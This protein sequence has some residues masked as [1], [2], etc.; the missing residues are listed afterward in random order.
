MPMTGNGKVQVHCVPGRTRICVAS[1]N[2]KCSV[3]DHRVILCTY[4]TARFSG[5]NIASYLYD[6]ISSWCSTG[7]LAP[8]F[9]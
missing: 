8:E 2:N 6:G 1:L 7:A 9:I 5:G 3:C 4:N